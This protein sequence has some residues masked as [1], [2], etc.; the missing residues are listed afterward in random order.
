MGPWTTKEEHLDSTRTQSHGTAQG[1]AKARRR[2]RPV[3]LLSRS[4]KPNQ[5]PQP[6]CAWPGRGC[7]RGAGRGSWAACRPQ[8]AGHRPK[9]L[10]LKRSEE[11]MGGCKTLNP[12]TGQCFRNPQTRNPH[13]LKGVDAKPQTLKGVCGCETP[14]P[15]R[16][17]WVRNPE[18]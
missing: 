2:A 3:R 16:S 9:T 10:N 14:N 4:I 11:C 13:T 5:N 18:P 6:T 7:G 12:K 1:D 17:G 15:Q 8:A